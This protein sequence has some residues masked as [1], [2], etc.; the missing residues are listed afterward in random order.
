MP[1]GKPSDRILPKEKQELQDILTLLVGKKLG[2]LLTRIVIKVS[3][4]K[5]LI[6]FFKILGKKKIVRKLLESIV[7]VRVLGSACGTFGA[8]GPGGAL[9]GADSGADNSLDSGGGNGLGDID[10][11][12]GRPGVGLGL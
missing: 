9:G 1:T 6:K 8:V 3:E 10:S 11:T 7:L 2:P 4:P 5:F 12:D